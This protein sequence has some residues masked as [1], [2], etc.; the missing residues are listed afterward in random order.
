M[1][2]NRLGGDDAFARILNEVRATQ[3][4]APLGSSSVSGGQTRFIGN[5]SLKV[6]GSMIVSGW[7]IIT[8]TLKIVGSLLLEGATTMTGALISS[9]TALFTGLFTVRGTTRLEGD[10]TQVGAHHVQ[11]NQD[12]TGTLAVKSAA[13]LE[14]D[15]TLTAGGRIIAGL[16]QMGPNTGNGG[17]GITATSGHL[18]LMTS[19]AGEVRANYL[20]IAVALATEDLEVDGALWA[21]GGITTTLPL[22]SGAAANV[23]VDSGGKLWRTS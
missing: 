11:G 2:I 6:I 14:D 7:L 9:G 10:T 23:H 16:L 12:I 8:G 1:R 21:W 22:K 15:L 20:R 4:Q 18:S 3:R 13:T 5:E 17:A 19:G